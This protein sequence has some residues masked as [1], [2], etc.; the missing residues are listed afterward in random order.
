MQND[1]P[2]LEGVKSHFDHWRATR[3]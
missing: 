1:I 3:P 2:S